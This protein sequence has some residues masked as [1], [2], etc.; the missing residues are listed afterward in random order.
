MPKLDRKE[1]GNYNY[2]VSIVR[3]YVKNRREWEDKGIDRLLAS[4]YKWE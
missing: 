4:S 1:N 2:F 3:C